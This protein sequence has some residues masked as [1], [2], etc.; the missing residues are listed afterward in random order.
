M[1]G[2]ELPTITNPSQPS[3]A[4]A[5]GLTGCG[6]RGTAKPLPETVIGTIPKA[7]QEPTAPAFKLKGDPAAGKKIFMSAGCVSCHTLADAGAT[8][9]IGP[10]LDQAKPDYKLAT[11]RVTFGKGQMPSFKDQLS[12]QQIADVA[13]YVVT[14]TGG[15]P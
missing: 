15:T 10:N 1:Y 8:G 2:I 13:T 9:T 12:T 14:A 11:T 7:Q 4:C 6:S 3:I 5:V